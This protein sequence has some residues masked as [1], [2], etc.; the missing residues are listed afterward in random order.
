[1]NTKRDAGAIGKSATRLE[2]ASEPAFAVMEGLELSLQ[3]IAKDLSESREFLSTS[4]AQIAANFSKVHSIARSGE[5]PDA[6]MPNETL[7]A[8][9]RV[10]NGLTVELQFEDALSQSL[11][12][13][14][15]RIESICV[16]LNQA[17]T[18]LAVGAAPVRANEAPSGH[19]LTVL[20][21]TLDSL[22]NA[23]RPGGSRHLDNSTGS[24]DLF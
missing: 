7:I 9:R 21:R 1:M 23:E 18:N 3:N 14:L 19:A 12:Y 5:G 13:A 24:V 6:Q 20:A 4:F 22:R 16:A 17:R 8:L 10:V 2:N 15:R 11:S